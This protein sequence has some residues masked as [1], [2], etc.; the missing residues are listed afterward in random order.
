MDLLVKID[1]QR[2]RIPTNLNY[3]VEGSQKFVK[4]HF[5]FTEN[6]DNLT[7]FA[8]F[9]QNKKAYN[10]Y[11]DNQNCVYLPKEIVE[12]ECTLMLY[13]TA[14]DVIATTNYLRLRI[15]KNILV[16]NADST[17]IS[18]SLYNQ[19]VNKVNKIDGR[20]TNMINDPLFI[21]KILDNVKVGGRNL[22]LDSGVEH[23]N[24]E[25][26]IAEYT[27]SRILKYGE[28]VTAS[29]CLTTAEKVTDIW[30]Y[31]S[32][33]WGMLASIPVEANKKQIITATFDISYYG[34]RTPENDIHNNNIEIYRQP[35]YEVT[36]ES[37]IHWIKLEIGTIAT[38]WTEAPE[39]VQ[40]DIDNNSNELKSLKPIAKS[41]SFTDLVNVPN[42]VIGDKKYTIKVSNFI[43][44]VD[45][46]SVITIV[47]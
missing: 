17:E 25:Y 47:I 37:T 27:P 2:V 43:P 9:G 35:R 30:I 41:A 39:D 31:N 21:E 20:V 7:V 18:T 8:Q 14:G 10:V 44:T 34:D 26:R 28:T 12:G 4:F 32:T 22:L 38:D 40:K 36:G 16:E 6:W 19:L 3:A 46:K 33:G 45:D 42:I 1:N 29:I 5:K 13:G 24:T 15:D 11:L 23:T